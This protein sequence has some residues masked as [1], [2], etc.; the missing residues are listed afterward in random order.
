MPKRTL[1]PDE[2]KSLTHRFMVDGH[3]VYL[4]VGLY[5]DGRPGELFIRMGKAGSTVDGFADGV[6]IAV[7]YAMQHNVPWRPLMRKFVGGQFAPCGV[8]TG[9]PTGLD[10]CTSVLDYAARWLMLRFPEVEVP[11]PYASDPVAS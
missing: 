10:H 5:H 1:L 6:A 3:K 8:V 11:F 2:R 7:S 9:G 4:T